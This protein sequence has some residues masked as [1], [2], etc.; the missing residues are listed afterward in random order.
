MSNKVLVLLAVIE[1]SLGNGCN[2]QNYEKETIEKAKEVAESYI[3]NNYEDFDTIE[4]SSVE[5]SPMGDMILTGEV[6][7]EAGFTSEWTQKIS[8]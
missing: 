1:I 8:M 5:E 7:G 3:K 4:F 2:N 6:N